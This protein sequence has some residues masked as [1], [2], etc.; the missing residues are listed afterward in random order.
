MALSVY[1]T[2]SLIPSSAP[3]VTIGY[4]VL[5]D[6]GM[7]AVVD[8]L[9]RTTPSRSGEFASEIVAPPAAN[10]APWDMECYEI[11]TDFHACHPPEVRRRS[12][13]ASMPNRNCVLLTPD[14][15]ETVMTKN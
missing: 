13:S 6:S 5:S 1:M 12:Y 10:A 9:T 7:L 2:C 15:A 8:E 11:A 14:G 3:M 4:V